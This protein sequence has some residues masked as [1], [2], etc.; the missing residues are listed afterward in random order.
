MQDTLLTMFGV[1]RGRLVGHPHQLGREPADQVEK[2]IH[3]T[4][5]TR[6]ERHVY[7]KAFRY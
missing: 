4:P 7:K 6:R 5:V 1:N 2:V 3:S